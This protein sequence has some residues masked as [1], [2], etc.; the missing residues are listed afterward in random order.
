[1]L[2]P[3]GVAVAPDGT[4]YFSDSGAD[5][6]SY[7]RRLDPNGNAV[8][9]AGNGGVGCGELP[10]PASAQATSQ[11]FNNISAMALRRDSLSR[12]IESGLCC[13]VGDNVI[14]FK[15]SVGL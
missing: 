2:A 15:S 14:D 11:G 8:I 1:L 6:R 7:V 12:F 10:G 4:L 5:G 3:H 9:V 13:S